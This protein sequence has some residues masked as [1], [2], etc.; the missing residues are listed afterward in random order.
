MTNMKSPAYSDWLGRPV[1][2]QV[3]TGESRVPIR[4]EVLGESSEAVRFR[5]AEC[6][7]MDIFKGMIVGVEPDS[8]PDIASMDVGANKSR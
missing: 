5:I 3:S 8:S 7:D 2:L 4:E 6:C 1:L